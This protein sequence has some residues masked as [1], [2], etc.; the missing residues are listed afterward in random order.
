MGGIERSPATLQGFFRNTRSELV[1]ASKER[2][3][4]PSALKFRPAGPSNCYRPIV[5]DIRG[6]PAGR[7]PNKA[8]TSAQIW[9]PPVSAHKEGPGRS[10]ALSARLALWN[11]TQVASAP[12]PSSL[13]HDPRNPIQ[14]D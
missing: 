1:L 14:M 7:G 11:V 4:V 8:L 10:R 5:D 6:Y 13:A 9:R 2:E 3:G 12:I